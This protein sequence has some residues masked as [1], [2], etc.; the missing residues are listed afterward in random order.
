M[1]ILRDPDWSNKWLTKF[2][3]VHHRNLNQ[4]ARVYQ[5]SSVLIEDGFDIKISAMSLSGDNI[6]PSTNPTVPHAAGLVEMG[7]TEFEAAY[8]AAIGTKIT[9]L[10]WE[11]NLWQGYW[12]PDSYFVVRG[13]AG[14]NYE[15]NVQFRGIII[16]HLSHITTFT[17]FSGSAIAFN[18]TGA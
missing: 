9:Y 11:D 1:S 2:G 6:P 18:S 12:E 14:C 15:I 10:D 8:L 13:K 5:R 3:T 4:D 17:S 16:G 7:V